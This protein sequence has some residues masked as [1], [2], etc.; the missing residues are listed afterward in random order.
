MP[1]VSALK[2]LKNCKKMMTEASSGQESLVLAAK[3]E[4]LL[5]TVELIFL[6]FSCLSCTRQVVCTRMH[7]KKML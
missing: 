3:V 5:K 7:W 6:N 2:S 4:K 1:V